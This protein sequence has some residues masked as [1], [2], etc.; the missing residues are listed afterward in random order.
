MID[1]KKDRFFGCSAAEWIRRIPNELERDAVG[2]WQIVPVG[3]RGFGL[4]GD[5]LRE[6]VRRSLAAV[7]ERGAVPAAYCNG[8]WVPTWKHG[9]DQ[10][11]I[12]ESITNEWEDSGRRDPD[13]DDLWLALPSD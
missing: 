12:L 11:A 3:R 7:L 8:K 9:K 13:V 5:E 4:E 6:F 2:F 10:K 1:D